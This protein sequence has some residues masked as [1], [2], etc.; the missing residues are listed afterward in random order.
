MT[1]VGHA[2]AANVMP[3]VVE[4]GLFCVNL[5]SAGQWLGDKS[6]PGRSFRSARLCPVMLRAGLAM[7]SDA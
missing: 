6:G 5:Q 7:A 4:V 2:A 1:R 3:A